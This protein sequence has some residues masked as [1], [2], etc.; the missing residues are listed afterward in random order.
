MTTTSLKGCHFEYFRNENNPEKVKTSIS[1]FWPG[2]DLT[3]FQEK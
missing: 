1:A 2:Y 3:G